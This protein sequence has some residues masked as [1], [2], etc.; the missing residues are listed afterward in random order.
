MRIE[1]RL[2]KAADA[3]GIRD[4]YTPI[5]RDT[6]ISFEARPPSKTEIARRIRETLRETPWL[7]AESG[8]H[9]LGYAYATRFR[10]R[11]AYRWTVEVTVY[12]AEAR[13]GRGVGRRLYEALLACLRAQGF[14]TALAVI[15][16]PNPAS[17][18][19]HERLGFE[20]AGLLPRVGF[21]RGEW[22]DV[23]LWSL[24]LG[25]H[26]HEPREPRSA[27]EMRATG[28]WEAALRHAPELDPRS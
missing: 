5:V 6:A 11:E 18:A 14:R 8:R 19:L 21:K 7:V 20:R 10:D 17:V 27:D 3:A 9:V 22:H 12:V 23:G 13:Q 25:V 1:T 4:I 28:A 15:A 26:D 2:A 16:L 24:A